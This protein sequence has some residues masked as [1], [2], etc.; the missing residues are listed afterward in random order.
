MIISRAG[1][2]AHWAYRH[3]AIDRAIGAAMAMIEKRSGALTE[4]AR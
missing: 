3:G 1:H 4:K 2:Q